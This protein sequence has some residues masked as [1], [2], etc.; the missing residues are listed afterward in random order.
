MTVGKKED[1]YM[2]KKLFI[3]SLPYS[4]RDEQLKA[5][6]EKM[7]EVS[8]ASVVMDKF[9]RDRSRGFGFVEMPNDEEAQKAIDELNGKEL[10]GREI[11]VSE[12]RP[13]EDKPAN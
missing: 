4:V 5:H 9:N 13:K 11:T 7:G 1:K 6:F 8:S 10:E 2:A 3:G 12:A